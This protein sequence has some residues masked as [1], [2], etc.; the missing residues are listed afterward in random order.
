MNLDPRQRAVLYALYLQLDRLKDAGE[1]NLEPGTYENVSGE[2]VEITLPPQTI[3]EREKGTRGDGTIFKNAT[4]NLYGYAFLAVLIRTLRKFN[5]WNALRPHVMFALREA[6]TKGKSLESQLVKD[7]PELKVE[8]EKIRKELPHVA[9]QE[10][11]PRIC[12]DMGF[13]PTITFRKKA[14]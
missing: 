5:Q 6:V 1:L 13:F 12:K 2:K 11:T 3:V 14:A 10:Q 7:D 8:I 9:R 4:Q